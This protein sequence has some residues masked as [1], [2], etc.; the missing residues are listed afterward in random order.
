MV[1]VSEKRV[2]QTIAGAGSGFRLQALT[3]RL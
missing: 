3:S 2:R 1:Q